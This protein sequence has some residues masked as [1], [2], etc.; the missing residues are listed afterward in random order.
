MPATAHP[1]PLPRWILDNPLRAAE[2]EIYDTLRRQLPSRYRLYYSSPWLGTETDGSEREGE[3][4]FVVASAETGFLAI[5][6]KGGAVGRDRGTGAWYSVDRWG[7]RHAIKNPVAQAS[8]AKHELLR[9][10][11]E[12]P[13]MRNR[14]ISAGIAV[15]FP[16][17][18]GGQQLDGFD[19]PREKFA[20]REEMPRLGDW[21]RAHLDRN[22]GD[23]GQPI[24]PEGLDALDHLLA[25]A[26]QLRV[27]LASS[28]ESDN[29]RI[30]VATTEQCELL[31]SLEEHRRAAIAGVAG[32]GKTVLALH[33]ATQ[34]S[35][36]NPSAR[37]LLTCFNVPLGEHLKRVTAGHRNIVAGSFHRICAA[38]AREAGVDIP[39]MEDDQERFGEAYPM[40]LVSAVGERPDLAFDAVIV[41]E[42]QDFSDLW[43][44][45]LE[46]TIASVDYPFWVFYDDNQRLYERRGA[47]E[48]RFPGPPFRLKR[49][50]RNPKPVFERLY[51]LLGSTVATSAGPEGRPVEEIVV[52]DD[53]RMPAA[54]ANLVTRL[55][56]TDQVDPAQIAVLGTTSDRLAELCPGSRFGRVQTCD[57]EQPVRGRVCLDT[58]R[59]FK[60]LERGVIILVDPAEIAGADELQYVGLSRPIGHLILLG[61]RMPKQDPDGE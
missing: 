11:K 18:T 29:R 46:Q 38:V 34:L 30:L 32:S 52:P 28:L 22:M 24:G 1:D 3:A 23:R 56:E 42:A 35:E 48:K 25:H 17:S 19:T 57:A 49:N 6:V 45:S 10:L 16:H 21:V 43:L 40:A 8:G 27:P 37:V 47:I 60:G 14:F 7:A 15:I 36:S 58:V 20:L 12:M 44:E 59:R 13:T 53:R 26:F 55:V 4:D 51:P 33:K 50:V 41:D 31:R 5:E 2:I 54:L 39:Y 61:T 9:R